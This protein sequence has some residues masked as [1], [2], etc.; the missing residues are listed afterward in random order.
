M[1]DVETVESYLNKR[2]AESD[3]EVEAPRKRGRISPNVEENLS[4]S[5]ITHSR[6]SVE[7]AI[8][9]LD[10]IQYE[11]NMGNVLVDSPDSSDQDTPPESEDESEP[12]EEMLSQ[13]H[14]LGF[15][16][17]IRETFRFLDSCGIDT[18]NEIYKQLKGRFVEASN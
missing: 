8:R 11:L 10:R 18:D 2:K 14:A 17:C 9:A 3:D 15:A 13:A 5:Q 6:T 16:A 7:E 4:E 12:N 1:S